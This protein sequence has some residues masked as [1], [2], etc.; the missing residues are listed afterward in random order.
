MKRYSSMFVSHNE[1]K[2]GSFLDWTH[3]WRSYQ[4]KCWVLLFPG[5][6]GAAGGAGRGQ[7]QRG[8]GRQQGENTLRLML[9]K[10]WQSEQP[11]DWSNRVSGV[12]EA[13]RAA[14]PG[15]AEGA[16]GRRLA[17]PPAGCRQGA[18][19]PAEVPQTQGETVL[20]T[21]QVDSRWRSGSSHWSFRLVCAGRRR[22]FTVRFYYCAWGAGFKKTNGT[23][24]KYMNNYNKTGQIKS[25]L[26]ILTKFCNFKIFIFKIKISNFKTF[27]FFVR[28]SFWKKKRNLKVTFHDLFNKT[29]TYIKTVIFR[30]FLIHWWIFGH[31]V[32]F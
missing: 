26:K 23:D 20:P 15:A 3:S 31:K 18:P 30:N 27:K 22:S 7:E 14:L 21:G 8:H 24:K 25:Y 12:H 5:G 28:M 17:G 32:V 13:R 11:P 10:G 9:L 2:V 19:G 6:G 29:Y 4:S 1:R 16:A